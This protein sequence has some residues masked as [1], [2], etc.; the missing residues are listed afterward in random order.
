MKKSMDLLGTALA[1]ILKGVKGDFIFYYSDNKSSIH[2]IG[3][4]LRTARQLAP[5]EKLL[6]SEARGRILD[7]G[8]ATGYYLPALMKR[9]EAYGIEISPK[10][11]SIAKKK[12]LQ[13]CF[14]GDIFSYSSKNKFDTITL[15]ENNIG[16]GGDLSGTNK[17]LKKIKS[18]LNDGGQVL[19][20]ARNIDDRDYFKIKLTPSWRGKIGEEFG[21]ISFNKNYL[22]S[23]FNKVGFTCVV[24]GSDMQRTIVR[25]KLKE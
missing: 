15:L 24:I 11:V 21:W 7:I 9:G 19:I 25:A 10:L 3:R 22:M 4:Y 12:G 1:D 2:D 14:Q 20:D 13:N 6:I 5:L 16:L 23:L 18:L 17:L 8:C